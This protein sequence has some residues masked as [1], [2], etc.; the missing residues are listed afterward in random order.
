MTWW[1]LSN[2][3]DDWDEIVIVF[4][5]TG[6]ENPETLEF[7]DLCDRLLFMP[8]GHRVVWL[9][10][11][12][13]H[14]ERK[15]ATFR[16]VD[17]HTADR[18]GEVFEDGIKKYGIPNYKRPHCTRDLKLAPI[19]AYA[20]S[21]GWK[22][23]TY[24]TAIGIRA[25]EIDRMSAS[26]KKNRIIYPLV[27]Y[28]HTTKPEVNTW[29]SLQSFRLKLKGYQGNC[30]WCWKKSF[31]KHLTLIGE[32]P[33]IY[34]FPREMERKYGQTG[35]E[36]RKSVDLGF[37][38]Y[39]RTFFRGNKST[40]D[41]FTMFKERGADFTPAEDDS[42][43]FDDELDMGGGCGDGE[44]C[45]VFSDTSDDFDW[46]EHSPICAVEHSPIWWA[47]VGV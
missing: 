22:T 39:S 18:T 36:F 2:M 41:I 4:A 34:D 29:F 37:E 1:L 42:I 9:E 16:V 7:V 47:I 12:Q 24:D 35:V 20:R 27:T 45:E 3:R 33:E 17:F 13:F 40:D 8:L 44:S 28:R 21:L 30:R 31:R 6:Q 11:V 15:S 43:V 5:N 14:G 46:N 23:A 32:A 25:D 19:Q 38:D 26:S 10:A